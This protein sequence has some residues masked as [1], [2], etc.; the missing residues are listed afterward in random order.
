[1][2]C[3]PEERLVLF[4]PIIY[5]TTDLPYSIAKALGCEGICHYG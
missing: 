5:K 4:D 2:I 1:M 3:V